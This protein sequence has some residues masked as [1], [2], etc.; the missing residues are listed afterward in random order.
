M[1]TLCEKYRAACFLDIKGQDFAVDK[2]KAFIRTFPA[3]RAVL[4]HGPAGTGKT[5]LAYALAKETGSEILEL[6]A[7]D[8][9]NKDQLERILKPATEQLSL[10][11]KNKI[12][13]IDEVDGI[14]TADR[15]GLPELL[16]LIE[17]TKFPIIVT[18]ND[19]WQQK[20]NLLRR[21]TDL[22]Q[23]K[24]LDYKTILSILK[25]ISEK[26]KIKVASDILASVAIKAKGDVRAALN[27]LQ[28]I[29]LVNQ[30][31]EI[32]ERDK[33]EDIFNVLRIIFKQTAHK[34]TLRLYDTLNMPL[35]E[36]RLWLEENIP[37]E[38]RGK[39]LYNAFEAL[40]KADVFRGRIHRQQHWRFL[41]YQNILLS[42]GVS[43]AKSA[44]RTGFTAYKKPSRILKIWMANQR[45]AK[46]KS[47]SQK[48]AALCHISIKRAV[49]DFPI[50]RQ[51]ITNKPD[52]YKSLRLS[53][54]E[55]DFLEKPV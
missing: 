5:S 13:L 25:E 12:I 15:G 28:T 8:L 26:E 18:A 34:E 14:S 3:K 4:L 24:N 55:I 49:K 38:Y 42:A 52:I 31:E 43:S 48:Y 37:Y 19:I 36:I 40:S 30:P 23:F 44:P 16:M 9:R 41:V 51:I 35:D 46:R 27:D 53:E 39:E 22:I 45:N 2:I 7:S 1:L 50:I 20:F 10:F 17:K 29:Q 11:G 54:E 21:K 32:S 33:E 6:N 47:I